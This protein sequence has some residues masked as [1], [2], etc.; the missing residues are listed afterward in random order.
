MVSAMDTV[1]VSLGFL[2]LDPG[3][4]RFGS[5][6]SF[7]S[8]LEVG[9]FSQRSSSSSRAVSSGRGQKAVDSPNLAGGT[10]QV[11]YPHINRWQGGGTFFFLEGE[12]I[13]SQS[14]RTL[15]PV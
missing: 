9:G 10:G 1:F 3:S 5:V 14:M 11:D 4:W 12:T 6:N 13:L 2:T 7:T 15:C 8:P